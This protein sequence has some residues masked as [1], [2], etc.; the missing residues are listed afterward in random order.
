MDDEKVFMLVVKEVEES[1]AVI[2]FIGVPDGATYL[3]WM[4]A[5]EYLMDRVARMSH[6]P[7]DEAL[8]KLCEG[9]KTYRDPTVEE[10]GGDD[11]IN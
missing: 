6:L 9:A 2:V 4:C 7:F 5:C 1:E 10:L 11:S 8:A 3:H